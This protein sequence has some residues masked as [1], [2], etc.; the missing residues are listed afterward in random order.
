MSPDKAEARRGDPGQKLKRSL[1][2]EHVSHLTGSGWGGWGISHVGSRELR[3]QSSYQRMPYDELEIKSWVNHFR[4]DA[5]DPTVDLSERENASS[6][7][8]S[9]TRIGGSESSHENIIT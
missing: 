5:I 4:Q 9:K 8:T 7:E 1:S 6:H 2:A 3:H